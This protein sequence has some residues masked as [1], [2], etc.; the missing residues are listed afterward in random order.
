M[1]LEGGRVDEIE[2][3]LKIHAW[4]HDIK[5]VAVDDLNMAA[6]FDEAGNK[7]GGL[8]YFVLCPRDQEGI[9]RIGVKEKI[10]EILS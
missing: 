9:K 3:W 10:L 1:N 4:K 7:T 2:M 5:W 8:D 6:K